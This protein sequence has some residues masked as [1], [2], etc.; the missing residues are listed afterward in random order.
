[1]TT[2]RNAEGTGNTTPKAS[3]Q[4]PTVFTQ[5]QVN[6]MMSNARAEGG[7]VATERWKT[8]VLDQFKDDPTKFDALQAKIQAEEAI[9]KAE[10]DSAELEALRNEKNQWIAGQELTKRQT[11][12]AELAK[13]KGVD[14]ASLIKFASK[15][16]DDELAALADTLPKAGNNS[17]QQAGTFRPDSG[18]IGGGGKENL[19][20]LLKKNIKRM[21][22][23]E[24]E[25]HKAAIKAAQKT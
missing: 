22:P 16:S 18:G 24:L 13:E 12:A 25:E 6:R 14:P 1:M 11:K 19:E 7:K 17:Q 23:K 10:A 21:S 5:D 8:K 2:D 9:A 4:K 3:E 15:L 20:V